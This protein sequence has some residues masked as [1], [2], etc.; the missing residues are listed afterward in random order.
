M[1]LSH[2]F[3][4][5]IW[6]LVPAHSLMRSEVPGHRGPCMPTWVNPEFLCHAVDGGVTGYFRRCWRIGGFAYIGFGPA[7]HGIVRPM[8]PGLVC[9]TAAARGT[10]G[11][12]AR[13]RPLRA[14]RGTKIGI[15]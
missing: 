8:Q 14:G 1:R 5:R 4:G 10:A 12:W 15:G 9:S 7:F 6:I 13:N 3:C 2:F 11:S